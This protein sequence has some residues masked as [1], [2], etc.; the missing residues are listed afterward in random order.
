MITQKDE[1]AFLKMIAANP[2]DVAT[3]LVFADWLEE[4]GDP[5]GEL[6]RLTCQLTERIDVQDRVQLEARLHFLVG[7][8]VQAIGPFETNT[9]GMRLAWIPPGT[10]LMGSP[11]NEPYWL[12]ET[13]QVVVIK[14]FLIGVYAVTQNEWRQVM[15]D[16]PSKF[17]GDDL[18]VETISWT[19]SVA[20]CN[21]LSKLEGRSCFY[22]ID[23]DNVTFVGSDGYRLPTDAEWEYACRAGTTT[24]YYWGSNGRKATTY[25]WVLSN[26]NGHTHSVGMKRP[27]AWG[28]HDMHGNVSEWCWDRY[29][30]MRVLR[31]GHY[32]GIPTVATSAGRTHGYESDASN[33]IGL[34]ICRG[35]DPS[36]ATP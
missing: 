6:L 27:N 26:S 14:S 10:F 18:P 3:R 15:K 21:A 25:A 28:L 20:F 16:N 23:G 5:R 35:A 24:R 7:K 1:S 30:N 8:R 19:S 32:G 11:A 31:G 17:R 9:I 34:R 12:Q 4:H 2:D 22:Q 36:H 33:W 29:L 13:Q